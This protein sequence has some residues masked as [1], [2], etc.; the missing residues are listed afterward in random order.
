MDKRKAGNI[1]RILEEMYG[2]P[3]TM[4][5]YGNPMELAIATILSAQC[6]DKQVN[7]VTEHLFQKYRTPKDYLAVEPEELEKDIHSTGFFRNKTKS[8]RGLCEA[9]LT[10][11]GG[12]IPD[13]MKELTALPGVGRKTA[14]IILGN[15]FGIVE[16]VAVDTH[17]A[18]LSGR[19]KF[20]KQKTPEKIE[21]DLMELFPKKYWFNLTYVLIEHGRAVC[22]ARKPDCPGCRLARLCPSARLAG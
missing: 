7:Q 22:K 20:S 13:T 8:I 17:V 3:K 11:H 9:I 5:R 14:N 12:E 2:T 21:R 16:G 18:R 1:Y 15:A 6:T 10:R 19:L 4:L